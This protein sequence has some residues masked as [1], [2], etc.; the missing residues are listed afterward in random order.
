[1]PMPNHQ[2]QREGV[3]SMDE[4][5]RKRRNERDRVRYKNDAEYRER[6]NARQ[7]ER[8][9]NDEEFRERRKAAERER[10]FNDHAFREKQLMLRRERYACDSEYRA[11]NRSDSRANQ[12]ERDYGIST[13]AFNELLHRQNHAC[14]ICERPFRRTPCADHCHITNWVRGL[15]CRK[16]NF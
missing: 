15:L 4:E 6:K 7:R 14:G 10:W 9:A 11:K 12:L 8:Y 1:S 13:Q 2:S 3:R 5:R 16:C